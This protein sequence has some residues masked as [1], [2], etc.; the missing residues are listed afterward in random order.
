MSWITDITAFLKIKQYKLLQRDVVHYAEEKRGSGLNYKNPSGPNLAAGFLTLKCDVPKLSAELI[1]I[2]ESSVRCYCERNI[3]EVET[4]GK[5]KIRK[6][7]PGV[8]AK[9]LDEFTRDS[10]HQVIYRIWSKHV[11]HCE[12]LTKENWDREM[13]MDTNDRHPT[14]IINLCDD[15]DEDESNSGD[16]EEE[17]LATPLDK[18]RDDSN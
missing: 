9:A 18:F 13:K 17:V 2:N 1:Q 11:D 16:D 12:K 14:L 7:I 10:I 3:D 5:K 8:S 4:P 15:D 6:P